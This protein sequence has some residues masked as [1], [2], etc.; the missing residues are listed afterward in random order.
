MGAVD[1]D[2]VRAERSARVRNE[3]ER[4]ALP[5]LAYAGELEEVTAEDYLRKYED[6]RE[7]LERVSRYLERCCEDEQVLL[8]LFRAW[9]IEVQAPAWLPRW[10]GVADPSYVFDWLRRSAAGCGL[11]CLVA[12]PGGVCMATC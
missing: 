6:G 7:R 5:L 9:G 2:L 1:A 11:L 10:R 8:E 12:R 3:R 4:R